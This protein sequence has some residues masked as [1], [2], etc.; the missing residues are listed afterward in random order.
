[1]QGLL[2]YLCKASCAAAWLGVPAAC[3]RGVP[4]LNEAAVLAAKGC[5]AT[6]TSPLRSQ[7]TEASREVGP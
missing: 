4:C 2:R 3:S 5:E 6:R 1:M 7:E